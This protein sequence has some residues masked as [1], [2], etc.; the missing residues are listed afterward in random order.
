MTKLVYIG[1]Y[2]HSGSTL[3]EYLMAG[4]PAVLACGEVVSCIRERKKKRCSCGRA[5]NECPVWGFLRSPNWAPIR[6]HVQLVYALLQKVGGQYA[7][8][9]DS[10]KTAWGSSSSPFRLKRKFGSD[11]LLVHLTRHPMGAC[12][13]VLKR[14][15]RK[16]K[17]EGRKPYPYVLRCSWT[18]L[19]WSVANLSCEL[20]GLIYP[21][22]YV[23]LRYEDLV[24]SPAKVLHSLF[25][26]VLPDISWSFE[27]ASTRHN[28]HQLY[29]N[30]VRY[31]PPAIEDVKEDL[32]WKTE[33]PR[34]YSRVVLALSYLLRVRYGY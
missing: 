4:S 14:S 29:G 24:R 12:W 34:E 18:V 26:K 15:D 10:S 33:M 13:S 1:G 2:G 3:L 5:A 28:R 8:I 17:K 31:R 7:A 9:V 25:E 27:D 11:F 21:R 32:K 19:G 6:T 23:R 30:T 16:A 22:N 20:F